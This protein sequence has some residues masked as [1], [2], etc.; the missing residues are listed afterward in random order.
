MIV[1]A[2]DHAGFKLKERL[3]Q[4]FKKNN[5]EFFDAGAVELDVQD[6]YVVYGKSAVNYF[7]NNCD[8]QKDKLILI[9]GSGIGMSIVANKNKNIRAVLAYSS[10]Q[11]R[12]GR[13]H[14]D[15]NCLCIGARNTC[16]LKTK[17][18]VKKFLNTQFLGGKYAER[19]NTI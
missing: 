14:N 6:S 15:C 7:V 19:I 3:K 11:A 8:I 18:I 16:F 12:Q 10:K 5:V 13:E 1:L 2:S 17:C 4:H 9:C